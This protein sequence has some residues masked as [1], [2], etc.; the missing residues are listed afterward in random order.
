MDDSLEILR[1]SRAKR[2]LLKGSACALL[3][4]GTVPSGFAALEVGSILPL[5]GGLYLAFMAYALLKWTRVALQ[6]ARE[7]I[8]I[9]GAWRRKFFPW[10]DIEGFRLGTGIYRHKIVCVLKPEPAATTCDTDSVDIPELNWLYLPDPF[11]LSAK[12]LINL[13]TE[14]Q[15]GHIE[16]T[17]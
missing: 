7:G 4:L 14:R 10:T 2:V 15:Q 5:L 6:I 9:C 8:T 12:D 17:A 11:G 13:L 3:L 1:M 16:S